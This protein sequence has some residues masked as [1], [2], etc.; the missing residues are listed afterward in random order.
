MI[1]DSLWSKGLQLLQC[2]Y[3]IMCGAM[4]WISERNLVSA[5]SNAGAFGVIACGAMTPELLNTEIQ[6]T[7]K[8]TN[9]TFGVNLI[10]MHPDLGN[11]MDVCID[12][13]VT[14]V[15]LAGGIPRSNHITKLHDANIQVITFAPNLNIAKKM[16]QFGVDGLVIE[17]SEAGGHIGP[18][19]LS[20][21]AQEILP[22]IKEVPIFVAGGIGSG[23][24]IASYSLMG[25]SGCQLGTAF[26]CT[27]ECIAHDNFK[28]VFIAANAKNAVSSIQID[29]EF[30]VIPVR[31]IINKASK[32]YL[33]FQQNT[34]N[35]YNSGIVS[36]KDAQLSIEKYWA[37]ALRKAVIDGDVENGSLMA[38]Q[39]VSLVN[40]V[41]PVKTVIASLMKQ[42]E[43]YIERTQNA[44]QKA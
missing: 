26:V 2:D 4:S 29:P 28:K 30:P 35:E 25:A 33:I 23:D 15:V 3:S 16:V 5:I 17:G 9:K 18:V 27:D 42:I 39:S 14:H 31:A 43:K 38:G 19:S 7:K 44:L 13:N 37:G 12:N 34:I 1:I 24:A 22:F 10:L 21:L 8:L 20:V 6:A 41:R 40:E 32:H 36:K 11:L